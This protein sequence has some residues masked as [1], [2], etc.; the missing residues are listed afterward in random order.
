MEEAYRRSVSVIGDMWS[1]D[2]VRRFNIYI[3][4][5]YLHVILRIYPWYY[6]LY[7][8]YTIS[9][10]V[11]K[12]L[13]SWKHMGGM[14]APGIKK[15][16]L[17]I[18]TRKFLKRDMENLPKESYIKIFK[19]EFSEKEKYTEMVVCHEMTH[20][21]TGHLSLPFWLNEGIA[22]LTVDQYFGRQT[23][24]ND[25][26]SHLKHVKQKVRPIDYYKVWELSLRRIGY[27]YI[28]AYWMTRYLREAH[29]DLIDDFVKNRQSDK[30]IQ[31]KI[32]AALGIKPR[33]LW[34]NIDRIVY[35][36]YKDRL[37]QV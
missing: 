14:A 15:S 17:V 32:S 7:Y 21:F 27:Y 30:L 2:K 31:R 23:I 4:S 37:E 5:N 29:P 3:E 1:V 12:Y 20:I 36:Y 9:Y 33:A 11:I 18:N 10:R 35:D 24:G 13:K 25:T 26:L 6:Y 22:M 16:M 28:R 19:A 8:A 34:S